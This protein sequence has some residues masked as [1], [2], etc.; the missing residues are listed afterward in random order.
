MTTRRQHK[1]A[2][3]ALKPG[4][5]PSVLKSQVPTDPQRL[6][7]E[8]K[9]FPASPGARRAPSVFQRVPGERRAEAQH[10]EQRPKEGSGGAQLPGGRGEGRPPVC[11]SLS[12]LASTRRP[13]AQPELR[14]LRQRFP[15]CWG[16]GVGAGWGEEEEEEEEQGSPG[17]LDA[18]QESAA[19]AGRSPTPAERG[20][21]Q[22]GPLARCAGRRPPGAAF[23]PACEPAGPRLLSSPLLSPRGRRAEPGPRGHWRP[24]A[25]SAWSCREEGK[26]AGG[27]CRRRTLASENRIRPRWRRLRGGRST[28]SNT[29]LQAVT[30]S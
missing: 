7:Q 3:T 1:A 22:A 13:V 17:A 12:S 24:R 25:A 10:W 29:A 4:K 9:L 21:S 27:C 15:S 26:V 14:Q 18:V 5:R 19:A 23:R 11:S 16:A 6:E 2:F 20:G 28:F 8:G 30:S